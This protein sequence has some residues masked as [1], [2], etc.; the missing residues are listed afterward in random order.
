MR[1]LTKFEL[2]ERGD[3]ATLGGGLRSVDV[4]RRLWKVGKQTTT[5][6]CECGGSGV[7]WGA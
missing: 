4:V 7:R 5:G 6:V 2:N 1:N 3:R